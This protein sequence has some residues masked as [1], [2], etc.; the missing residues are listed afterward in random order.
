MKTYVFGDSFSVEFSDPN[1]YP[2]GNLYC[3]WKGYVPKKYFHLLSEKF[4]STEIINFAMS[5]NDNEN[6]FEKFTEV[7]DK[8]EPDDLVIFGWTVFARFSICY[9]GKSGHT[10]HHSWSSSVSYS[11]VDWVQ[12]TM[13]NKSTHLYYDRQMK[14][15]NFINNVL[16]TNRVV[17]WT[18]NYNTNANSDT[19][20]MHETNGAVNDYHYNEKAHLDLYNKMIEEF[21]SSNKIQVDLWGPGSFNY[22][23]LAL[24]TDV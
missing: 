3:D 18:W 10:I 12:K 21:S 24:R 17:H 7:Y 23:N 11:T 1:L 19:T 16:K 14:L 4:G 20:I 15:I 8:I 9:Y 5:G 22:E 2:P 13:Q 6:I